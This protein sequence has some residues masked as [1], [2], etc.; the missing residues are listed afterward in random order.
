METDAPGQDRDDR[1]RDQAAAGRRTAGDGR[2]AGKNPGR[3]LQGRIRGRQ[4]DGQTD[5]TGLRRRKRQLM[6]LALLQRQR[7]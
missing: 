4:R 2:A 7:P 5:R 3:G 1:L 6:G